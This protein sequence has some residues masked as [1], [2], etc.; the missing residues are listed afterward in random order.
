[1]THA[2][3]Y[4]RGSTCALYH[5]SVVL[6]IVALLWLAGPGAVFAAGQPEAVPGEVLVQFR[7]DASVLGVRQALA[8]RPGQRPVTDRV[9]RVGLRPGETVEQVILELE[10]LPE[11]EFAEPNYL[12]RIQQIAPPSDTGFGQQWGLHN[13][14]QTLNVSNAMPGTEGIDIG[15][16]AAW[17]TTTGS[18]DIIVAVIDSGIDLDHPEFDGNLWVDPLT[19][20]RGR[21]FIGGGEPQDSHG[22]GTAM[23]GI[24]GARG[25]NGLGIAGVAWDVQLMALRTIRAD[26]TAS[27]DSIIAAIDYAVDNGAD[28]INGSFGAART[29]SD[30]EREAIERAGQRGVTFVA[31]ACNFGADN[32]DALRDNQQE[33]CYP[34]SYQLPN[35]IAV[36]ATDNGDGLHAQ[37]NYGLETVHLGAPGVHVL[38][39][40]LPGGPGEVPLSFH[41]GTSAAAAMVSGSV[42]LLLAQNPGLSPNQ[43][44]TLLMASA[45]PASN[46]SARTISGGRLNVAEALRRAEGVEAEAQG[47]PLPS[48]SL[49]DGGSG[50]LGA[51]ALVALLVLA[52]LRGRRQ[53]KC[54]Q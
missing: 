37:S 20:N 30:L 3:P 53:W 50:R 52:G 32:D 23:A 45:D 48:S 1:M 12:R 40:S 39:L 38:S 7:D 19:G 22:H 42:A 14:G 29:A 31:A 26:G 46:L 21:S 54:R 9:S 2:R 47:T 34:A 11:V 41:T 24:I 43:V 4:L 35:L 16:L 8:N 49:V 33:A 51:P 18:R 15:A 44:R 5:Q 27:V 10:S 28:V 36:A 25:N 17:A 13:S 6:V